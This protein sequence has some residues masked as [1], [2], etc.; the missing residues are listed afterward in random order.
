MSVRAKIRKEES[1]LKESGITEKYGKFTRNQNVPCNISD[2][3]DFF[4]FMLLNVKRT[5]L[6]STD[7]VLERLIYSPANHPASLRAQDSFSKFCRR[8]FLSLLCISYSLTLRRL[9]SYI[10]G[11]PILDVP[12][13][14]TTTQHSR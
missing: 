6:S 14:H 13:S 2:F 9:M 4:K 7:M 3:H 5:N 1:N 10:Y 8:D 11:A 12:R